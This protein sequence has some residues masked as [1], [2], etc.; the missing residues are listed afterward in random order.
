MHPVDLAVSQIPLLLNDFFKHQHTNTALSV[1]LCGR[2]PEDPHFDLRKQVKRLLETRMGCKAFLGED[3]AE[4]KYG[5]KPNV[6]HLTIE[7]REATQSDMVVM[8]LGSPGTI[9]EVTAFAMDRKINSKVIVFNDAK[10]EDSASFVN[11]GPLKL[12]SEDQI[13]YYDAT[14]EVP[15]V[16]LVRHLDTLFARKRFEYTIA[17]S[18]PPCELGFDA[19]IALCL[20]FASY[21]VKYEGLANLFPWQ[22]RRLRRALKVL[23][24]AKWLEERE[25]K[26]VPRCTLEEL[27]MDSG[28]IASLARARMILLGDR[29]RNADSVADYR[30]LL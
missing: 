28:F 22:E 17:D 26:Y 5:P 25:A 4:L 24:A 11:R 23:F 20:V 14:A 15:S 6:N 16:E 10:F 8:F 12:L 19:W 27:P 21:P 9:A 2:R 18:S 30:L 29:L 7:V 13:I 1:F 3:I